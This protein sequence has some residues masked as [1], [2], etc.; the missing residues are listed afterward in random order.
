MGN[1]QMVNNKEHWSVSYVKG[2]PESWGYY[3]EAATE[4]VNHDGLVLKHIT[5]Q[6]KFVNRPEICLNAVKRHPK[7]FQY[8]EKPHTL[9][10]IIEILCVVVASNK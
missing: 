3:T 1:N 10:N 4:A 6:E 8:I 5:D 7:A 9:P 2:N